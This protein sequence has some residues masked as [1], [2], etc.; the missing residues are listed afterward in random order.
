MPAW[1]PVNKGQ[2]RR[3]AVLA[4]LGAEKNID[5]TRE[6]PYVLVVIV[7]GA[8]VLAAVVVAI[9]IAVEAVVAGADA[10]PV[11]VVAAVV[12]ATAADVAIVVIVVADGGDASFVLDR[13]P[14][15]D[16]YYYL[17]LSLQ[18]RC[19]KHY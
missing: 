18:R 16:C 10:V 2:M 1:A 13:P 14:A 19:R 6:W 5:P 3:V 8:V 9:V 7:A 11:A 17:Q 15:P 12:V 4:D